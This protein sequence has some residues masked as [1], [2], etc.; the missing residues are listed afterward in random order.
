MTGSVSIEEVAQSQALFSD[1]NCSVRALFERVLVAA[2]ARMDNTIEAGSLEAVKRCAM[3]GLG[4]GILPSFAVEAE[5][6]AREL[7]AVPLHG[8]DLALD[9]QMVRNARSWTSPAVRA[10]W[11]MALPESAISSAA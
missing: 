8:V 4:F 2:G 10:L 3:A 1:T 9:I 7:V 11:E 6:R 5:I